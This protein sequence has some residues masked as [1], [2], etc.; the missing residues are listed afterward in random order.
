MSRLDQQPLRV[1]IGGLGTVGLPVAKWLDGGGVKGLVLAAVSA[2]DKGRAQERITGFTT[3]VPVVDLAMLAETCDVVVEAAPPQFFQ[4]IAEPA[5]KAGRIFIPLSVTSLLEHMDL[6]DL[7]DETGARII[8]PS[9]AL[10]GLDAVRAASR[11]T[12]NSVT[13]VTR[14]P[15]GGLKKA[16]FV[17]E[18]GIDLDGLTEPKLLYQG[19]VT[20]AA[21]K[22]PANVNVAVALGLAGIG[23]DNTAYEIWADPGVTRN[24]HTIK[25]DADTAS[26][27]MTIAN[28]PT[29]DNPATG[30]LVALSVMETLESLVATFKVGT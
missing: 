20:E 4:A 29:E 18:Q 30:K 2:A 24:T 12:I 28:V 23:P 10:L 27:E 21:A 7:A 14:K 3:D 5:I 25:V 19:T 15:P 11:G 1:G 13:M 17:I 22:F 26:F 8:V 6:V 16:V 9:G